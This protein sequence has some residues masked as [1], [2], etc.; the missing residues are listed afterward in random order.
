MHVFVGDEE[1][2][3]VLVERSGVKD[4]DV[5]VDGP[6]TQLGGTVAV[7]W[8]SQSGLWLLDAEVQ[9]L[10]PGRWRLQPAGPAEEIQRRA[11][12]RVPTSV[13]VVLRLPSRGTVRATTADLSETG[14]SVVVPGDTEIDVGQRLQVSLL[15]HTT[16]V[17][18]QGEVMRAQRTTGGDFELG[19]R[20]VPPYANDVIRRWVL[21]A[22]LNE[23][24]R[25]R[26]E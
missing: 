22:Q 3:V 7:Q 14:V 10:S 19:V 23:R 6:G 9:P 4:F 16:P 18:M 25:R 12:V 15:L 8:P 2:A 13:R 5:T 21:A 1:A 26:T 17:A 11:F 24:A 20:F